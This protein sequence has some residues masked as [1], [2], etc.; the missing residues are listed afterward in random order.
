MNSVSAGSASDRYL[1]GSAKSVFAVSGLRLPVRALLGTIALGAAVLLPA[2]IVTAVMMQ[3]T[4]ITGDP[5][6]S[7]LLGAA[8]HTAMLAVALLLIAWLAKGRFADY[9]LQWPPRRSYVLASIAWGTFFGF[10]MTAVDYL[11]QIAHRL[12]PPGNLSLAPGH[13]AAMLASYGVYVGPSEEIPFRGLMLTFLMQRSSG[14][15]RLGRYEMHAAGVILAL[16]FALAHLTSFWTINVWLALGQQL[17]AFALGILY[18][19][20]REKSGSLLAPILG[21]NFSDGVEY[22]LMFYLT[23][24][25]R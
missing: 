16:L 24:L 23:W 10:L 14:R 3:R 18:A 12:P 7:P 22:A 2:G 9:G 20:W 11:P 17:Y 19:Y 13:I 15:V 25:W 21:H 8:S 5:T 6:S 4:G 1:V